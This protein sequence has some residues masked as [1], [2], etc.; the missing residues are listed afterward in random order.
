MLHII[1]GQYKNR[2]ILSPLSQRTRPTTSRLREALFNICQ[3]YIEGAN[4]LDVFAGSGAM[5]IEAISRGAKKATFIDDDRECIRCIRENLKGLDIENLGRPLQG[6]ASALL[7]KLNQQGE[8]FDII[9]MDPPYEIEGLAEDLIKLID[10][11]NILQPGGML[12]MEESKATL[13]DNIEWH[14]LSLRSSR[15][16]GRS[17]L[18]QIEKTVYS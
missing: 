3:N 2:R 16:M 6:K 7:K 13:I 12:F 5:G 11:S 17:Q 18:L 10:E 1:S 8:K 9:Y 15:Q 4:F 14:T